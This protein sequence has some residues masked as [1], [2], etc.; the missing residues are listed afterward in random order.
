MSQHQVALLASRFDAI[1]ADPQLIDRDRSVSLDGIG[2]F[3]ALRSPRAADLRRGLARRGVS[4]D[5]RADI[6]RLG[7]APYLSD[8]QLHAAMDALEETLDELP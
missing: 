5:S 1:A 4:T 6:L 3:L 2:G 8:A 7:P